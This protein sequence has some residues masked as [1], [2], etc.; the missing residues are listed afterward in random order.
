M[1]GSAF[2]AV[3][4]AQTVALAAEQRTIPFRNTQ[5]A[6]AFDIHITAYGANRSDPGVT[7]VTFDRSSWTSTAASG[8]SAAGKTTTDPVKQNQTLSV[9]IISDKPV[10][11]YD[12]YWTI[13]TGARMSVS[14][15]D[16]GWV[17]PVGGMLDF[18]DGNTLEVPPGAVASDT[19]LWGFTSWDVGHEYIP[20]GTDDGGRVLRAMYL[21]PEGQTFL[22]PVTVRMSYSSMSAVRNPRAYYWDPD[23]AE[24][25]RIVGAQIDAVNQQVVFQIDHFSLYGLGG[26]VI[27]VIP[28]SSDWAMLGLGLVGVALLLRYRLRRDVDASGNRA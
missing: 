10:T 25:T 7:Q 27:E 11:S 14:A 21:G 28:A 5:Q 8:T 6:D 3:L 15:G 2:A 1:V 17:T 23:A 13:D 9:T 22:A 26:E 12:F 20:G 19:W 16:P 18:E 24:W 4:M